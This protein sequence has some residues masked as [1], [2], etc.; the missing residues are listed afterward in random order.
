[1]VPIDIVN[2]ILLY[3]SEINDNIIITQYHPI[4]NKKYYK[5][6]LNSDLLW[7]IKSTLIMKRIYPIRDGNFCNKN[8]INLYKFGIPHY[9]KQL[10]NNKIS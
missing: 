5:I 2:K 4:T 1:M 3:V 10:R 8:N 6:N 7:K 9:E